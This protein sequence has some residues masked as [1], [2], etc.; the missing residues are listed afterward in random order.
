M[1]GVSHTI[2]SV[3][4]VL[5][6]TFAAPQRLRVLRPLCERWRV[7]V[8]HAVAAT[9][10]EDACRVAMGRLAAKMGR[11]MEK[12]ANKASLESEPRKTSMPLM[13]F[14]RGDDELHALNPAVGG[15]ESLGRRQPHSSFSRSSLSAMEE[16]V[17]TV[18][19]RRR[20]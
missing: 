14:F 16:P 11:V 12:S 4:A 5:L 6:G 19:V 2:V 18:H 1:S 17:V 7:G 20:V 8:P 10:E 13:S 3:L 15:D 9:R